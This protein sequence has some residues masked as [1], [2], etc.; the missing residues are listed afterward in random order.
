MIL[1][2][3]TGPIP[4]APELRL[5]CL[6]EVHEAVAAALPPPGGPRVGTAGDWVVP[7]RHH[8]LCAV[9]EDGCEFNSLDARAASTRGP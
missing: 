6:V 4:G 1:A 9:L 7:R 5:R 3:V 8:H 2:A